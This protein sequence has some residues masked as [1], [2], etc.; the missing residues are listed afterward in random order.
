MSTLNY[1]ETPAERK[2]RNLKIRATLQQV[3]LGKKLPQ[4]FRGPSRYEDSHFLLPISNLLESFFNTA[5]YAYSNLQ[6]N[7]LPKIWNCSYF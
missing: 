1:A 4:G 7:L 6:Q 2:H 3:L 5:E